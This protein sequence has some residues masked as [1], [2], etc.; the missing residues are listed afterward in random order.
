M[1]LD[2]IWQ[3]VCFGARGLRRNPGFTATAILSLVL[4]IGAS[5]AI[6]TVA[7]NLLLRPL[8]YPNA[9]R[10]MI[11]WEAKA[12]DGAAGHNSVSPANYFDWAKQNDVFESMAAYREAPAVLTFGNHTDELKR[13]LFTPELLPM[14]GVQ[15]LRGRLFTAEDARFG[16]ANV[17]LISYRVWQSWFGGDEGVHREAGAGQLD[18]GDDC[19]SA[20][21]GL[22]FP[23][24]GDRPLGAVQSEPGGGLPEDFGTLYVYG[25]AAKARRDPGHGADAHGGAREAIGGA[26]RGGRP[27]YLSGGPGRSRGRRPHRGAHPCPPGG[28]AGTDGRATRVFSLSSLARACSTPRD[29]PTDH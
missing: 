11:V 2:T 5:L 4:G 9:E 1:A 25:S 16:A 23:E 24:P 12:P 13:Q 22:L 3:D 26:V 18:A 7:D 15:P 19:R 29:R 6:F 20:A 8:P 17:Q 14:L 21:A 27:R 10:L 28:P